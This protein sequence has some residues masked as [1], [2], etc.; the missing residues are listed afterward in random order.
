[1]NYKNIAI[2]LGWEWH[3]GTSESGDRDFWID[4]YGVMFWDLPIS[5]LSV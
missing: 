5:Y 1:M 4:C 3:E 2:S